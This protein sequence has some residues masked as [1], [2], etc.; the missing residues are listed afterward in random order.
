MADISDAR[1]LAISLAGQ[2]PARLAGLLHAR[3]AA[4]SVTWR[5]CFDAAEAM[6]DAASLDHAL[7]ALARPAVRA[8]DAAA[9]SDAA[10]AGPELAVLAALGLLREDGRPFGAVAVRLR[11]ALAEHPDAT[12]EPQPSATVPTAEPVAAATAERAAAAVR[13]LTDLVALCRDQPLPVTGAGAVTAAERRR[14]IETGVVG[15]ADELDDLLTLAADTGLLVLVDRHWRVTDAG[16]GWLPGSLG[17]RWAAVAAGWRDSLPPALRTTDGGFTA[18]GTWPGALPL[19]AEWPAALARLRRRTVRWGLAA[20]DGTEPAWTAPLRAGAA[21]DADALTAHLPTE[22]DTIYLQADL[23]AIAPGPLRSALDLRLRTMAVRESGAQAS[24]Y[25]FTAE[26]IAAAVAA[27]EDA[28]SLRAFLSDLSL[29]SIPQPLDYLIE[30]TC[31]R[32][33]LVRVG[34]DEATGRTRV[35]STD[36]HLLQT[37]AVDQSLR[38]IGLVAD[39]D[40][41]LSRVS[42]D[43]VYWTLADARYPVVAVGPTGDVESL[44]RRLPPVPTPGRTDP[45]ARLLPLAEGLLARSRGDADAAWLTRELDQ[46]ARSHSEVTVTVRLPDGSQREYTMAAT[47]F[48]GGRL[49]GRDRTGDVERTLPVSHI[50]GVRPAGPDVPV[51]STDR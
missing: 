26:S 33:G 10:V 5:D 1:A 36:G 31:A 23:S 19:A 24:S 38:S 25:R 20:A 49:R 32:H 3:G 7:A 29:T 30:Q 6:L 21:G 14:L 48:G 50:L 35:R 28:A 42:R 39:G 34:P 8:L 27:G 41:L 46:A 40:G 15:G 13:S 22:I 11:A 37:I 51:H 47:G 17:E 18:I 4:A 9:S 2:E 44:R 45:A 12:A 16:D 43:A